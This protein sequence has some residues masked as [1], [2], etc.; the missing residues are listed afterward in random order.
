MGQ[1]INQ[2]HLSNVLSA[3]KSGSARLVVSVKTSA[4]TAARLEMGLQEAADVIEA[5][6]GLVQADEQAVSQGL[7]ADNEA[8][9]P[10]QSSTKE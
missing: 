5:L 7:D 6:E 1:N 4:G 8:E 10:Q 3:A 2:R 9:T